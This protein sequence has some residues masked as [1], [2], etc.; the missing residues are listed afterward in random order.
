MDT[1]FEF[2]YNSDCCE[3]SA[4]TVS[5]HRTL[6]GAEM[7]MEFHKVEIKKEH[8]DLYK[9]EEDMYL[10]DFDQWWGTKETKVEE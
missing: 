10:W 3:S 8:I 5:I 9:G 4:R 1:V 7:A 6:K 2:L